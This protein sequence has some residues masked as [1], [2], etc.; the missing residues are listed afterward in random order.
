[1]SHWDEQAKQWKY[2]TEPLKPSAIDINNL[3]HWIYKL[4]ETRNQPLTVLL[5]GVTP[6]IVNIH[7]PEGTRLFAIDKNMAMLTSVLPRSTSFIQPIA[8]TADWLHFPLKS[9]SFDMVIGDGCYNLLAWSEYESLTKAIKSLLNNEGGVFI[10]RFFLRPEHNESLDS[11]KQ[12]I[13]NQHFDNF[14][15]FKLTLLMTLQHDVN[16]GVCLKEVWDCWDQHFKQI[17]FAYQHNLAWADDAVNVINNYK[18]KHVFYT[19]PTLVEVKNHLQKNL[20]EE[21]IFI[22]SYQLGDHCP[23]FKYAKY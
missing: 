5:L 13:I 21:K 19:F 2:I 22:P 7:W 14:S 17:V 8:L 23:T 10:S 1:M 4:Y 3:T 18:N 15:A 6:E 16:K 20:R 12:K 9:A 11:L